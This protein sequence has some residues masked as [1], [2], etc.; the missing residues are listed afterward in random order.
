MRKVAALV[1]LLAAGCTTMEPN[2]GRPDPAVPASWPAGDS[3]L[4]HS[5]ATLPSLPYQ[6]VFRDPRLQTLIAQGLVNN[7]DLMVAAANIAA[8][9]EQY[10]IQRANQFPEIT[11]GGSADVQTR[12]SGSGL[13][14]NYTAGVQMPSF[15][16]DLFGRIR[17]QSH[18]ALNRYLSTEAGARATRLTLVS[19]IATAWLTYGS[20]ATLLQIARDT[21]TAAVKSVRLTRLRLE[22]GI[23]PR[24]DLRQAEQILSQARADLADQRTA[25]AQDVNLMQLLVGAP[26]DPNL[27]PRSIEEAAASVIPVPTGTDSYVLLRRPDVVQAEYTLRAANAD[28]GAARAA[29]FPRISLN[30]LLGFAGSSIGSL[31]SSLGAGAGVDATYSIFNAGAGRANVRLT[32]AQRAAAVA[33]YQR[34]IQ[35][36]FREVSDALARQGTLNDLLA[37]NQTQK[38][39]AADTYVL[40]E[41]RYREGIDPFLNVL[42][43]Q[44]SYYAAQRTQALG[45]LT[46]A[47]NQVELYQALGGDSLYPASPRFAATR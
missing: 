3:Y 42:D 2:Y 1:A 12:E 40:T 35:T 47:Q 33:T 41:A 37:A 36:A 11:A 27:L 29:L 14:A 34:A 8:A 30:A 17:S 7:R 15:E 6:Q 45:R 21:E 19:D 4:R 9:R 18:A 13:A 38:A 46:A 23:A 39:A 44:R 28:I 31:F 26:I 25:V 5:E 22:G 20:D 32:E 10:R 24:T 16:L 43:A